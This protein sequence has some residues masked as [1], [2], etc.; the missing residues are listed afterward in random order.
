[1]YKCYFQVRTAAPSAQLTYSLRSKLERVERAN[2]R[3]I[4][5]RLREGVSPLFIGKI[6]W[7]IN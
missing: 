1:M 3:G 6:D 2:R 7:F 4:V 5:S